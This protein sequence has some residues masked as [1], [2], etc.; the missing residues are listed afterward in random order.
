MP[1]AAASPDGECH[2]SA[3]S[4]VLIDIRAYGAARRNA[5][6]ATSLMS[7]GHPIKVTFYTATT[8]IRTF[9]VCPKT[10]GKG[11]AVGRPRQSAHSKVRT[12]KKAFAVG[13]LSG[14]R[15]SFAVGQFPHGEQK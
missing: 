11:F 13:L 15:Q 9:A 8:G 6:T 5:S 4:S 12:A 7:T 14:T 2:D 3:P 10:V 1:P